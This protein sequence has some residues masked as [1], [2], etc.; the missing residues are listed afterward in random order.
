MKR[1][2]IILLFSVCTVNAQTIICAKKKAKLP[3]TGNKMKFAT[4]FRSAT[5]SCPSG[6]NPIFT[7]KTNAEVLAAVSE[8]DGPDS[9]LNA[10]LLDGLSSASFASA[11]DLADLEES[12]NVTNIVTVGTSSGDFTS[13]AD[14]V[15]SLSNP[16]PS[17]PYLVKVGPGS[18]TISSQLTVPSGVTIEGSGMD[19][20]ILT[21]AIVNADVTDAA[22]IVLTDGAK[23]KNLTVTNTGVSGSGE[24]ATAITASEIDA[25]NQES[26]TTYS[27][28][29]DGVKVQVTVIGGRA[30]YGIE[31]VNA[32]V[33][34]RNSQVYIINGGVVNAGIYV[35]G[36]SSQ[37]V[38]VENTSVLAQDTSSLPVYNSNAAGAIRVSGATIYGDSYGIF[39]SNSGEIYVTNSTISSA[40]TGIFSNGAGSASRVNNSQIDAGTN[41]G[42]SS[43][44]S[45]TCTYVAELNGGAAAC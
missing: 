43:G 36:S 28:V 34:I 42:T 23:L 25:P 31:L 15:S 30:H 3:S 33:L 9:G 40:G 8:V 37:T 12:T 1:F 5:G 45:V 7:D 24:F 18:F 22:I 20:T 38:W 11:Q 19:T 17:N 29:I 6:F 35:N 39:T 27:T 41:A 14:A 2:L 44:G 4:N 13:V 26:P 16:S 21:G 10:D 32:D